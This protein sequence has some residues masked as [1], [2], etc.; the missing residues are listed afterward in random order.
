MNSNPFSKIDKKSLPLP[1]ETDY[2]KDCDVYIIDYAEVEHVKSIGEKDTDFIITKSVEECS[3][4]NRQDYL[5][6]QASDVGILNILKKIALSGDTSLL[7]Q[8]KR[9]GLPAVEKD[10]LGHD[11]E[12]VLDLTAYS[13]DKIEAFNAYKHGA[14][15]YQNLPE[16][17][18]GKL[19]MEE[20]AKLSDE[21]LNAYLRD[22]S[23]AILSA[24]KKGDSVDESK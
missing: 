7:N 22:K 8:T 14:E 3:R 11:V 24:S 5:D 2:H 4:V 19:S 23:E 16:D 20:V 17:L 12:Q 10:A 6:E 9:V 18:K 21:V 13:V 1:C 15:V